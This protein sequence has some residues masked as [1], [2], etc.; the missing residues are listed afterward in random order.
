[1]QTDDIA[2]DMGTIIDGEQAV[3]YGII[4][5]VGSLSDA[6]DALKQMCPQR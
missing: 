6:L 1:M 4:D 2:T 3:E 5:A